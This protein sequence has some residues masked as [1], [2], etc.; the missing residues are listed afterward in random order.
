MESPNSPQR[1]IPETGTAY[2]QPAPPPGGEAPVYPQ[3]NVARTDVGYAPNQPYQAG[4]GPRLHSGMATA[5][6][7]L[8]ILAIVTGVT[9]VGGVIL[10]LLAI[11]FGTIAARR[12]RRGEAL[13]HGRAVAGIVTGII[14]VVLAIG[15]IAL[16]A[17][18]FN[19]KAGK[20]LRSC[21][22]QAGTNQAQI[23]HC[24]SQF[25]HQITH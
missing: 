25:Q 12:A 14:G 10:G 8:G 16:G 5:A 3:A 13:G 2:P 18:L 23:Q 4:L 24:N 9:V 21:L 22:N 11:I 19:T 1:N 17:S 6:L 15:L 20:D 7:I